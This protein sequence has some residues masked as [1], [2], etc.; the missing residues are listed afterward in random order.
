MVASERGTGGPSS[1]SKI[2][3]SAHVTTIFYHEK[4]HEAESQLSN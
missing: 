4:T 1:I 3:K 2:L